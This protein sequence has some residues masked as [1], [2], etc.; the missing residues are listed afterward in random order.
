[1]PIANLDFTPELLQ[2]LQ[3][4][5]GYNI[6]PNII[7]GF[8]DSKTTTA[9]ADREKR[10]GIDSTVFW[11]NIGPSA[12]MLAVY[13]GFIPFLIIGTKVRYLSDRCRRY[14]ENYKFSFFIRF[15]IQSFLDFGVFALIQVN[16]VFFI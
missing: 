14:L 10:S 16:S 1:M 2:F 8:F 9:P 12:L 4:I 13:L 6:V 5:S 11:I 3:A 7:D 15:W